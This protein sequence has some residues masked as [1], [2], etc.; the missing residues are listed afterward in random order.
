MGNDFF[1]KMTLPKMD[2]DGFGQILNGPIRDGF[3]QQKAITTTVNNIDL[4]V[5][6]KPS[7]IFGD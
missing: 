6:N 4:S 5:Y 3:I 2:G 1:Q 7:I